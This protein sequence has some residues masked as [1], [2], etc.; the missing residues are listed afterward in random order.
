M[1][2]ETSFVLKLLADIFYT[3][4][5]WYSMWSSFYIQNMKL[6]KICWDLKKLPVEL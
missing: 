2:Y 4:F 5:D 1:A 6:F 3:Y